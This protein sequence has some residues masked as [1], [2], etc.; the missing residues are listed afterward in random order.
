MTPDEINK[1]YRTADYERWQK[2]DW[3]VGIEVKRSK[4]PNHECE[5]CRHL[6]GIYPKDFLF[7]G[8]HEKCKCVCVP[9]MLDGDE[10]IDYLMTKKVP[11]DKIVKTVS[12]SAIAYINKHKQDLDDLY[13]FKFN[14]KY[15]TK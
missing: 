7:I 13:W 15:F 5:I 9:L 12:Q 11:E 6:E 2:M 8:W 3:V 1:S 4:N 14:K 10:F